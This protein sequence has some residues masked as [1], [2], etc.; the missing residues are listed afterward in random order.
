M[1]ILDQK[2]AVR[3]GKPHAN[4]KRPRTLLERVGETHF[5]QRSTIERHHAGDVFGRGRT[6]FHIENADWVLDLLQSGLKWTGLFKRGL[7]NV[8]DIQIVENNFYV[9]G[10]PHA[11]AGFTIMQLSDLHIDITP[12]LAEAIIDRLRL[13]DYDLCV[14]TGDYKWRTSGSADRALA[15]MRKIVPYLQ[16]PA[17]AV[18]G[19]H[20][21]LEFVTPV[22]EMGLPFLLNETVVL[23][24]SGER[25]YLSGV[26]DPHFYETD[27]LQKTGD[28]IPRGAVSILLAHSPEI[29]RQAAA[30]GYDIVLSGHTHAGQICL[31]GRIPIL[32]NANCPR[33]MVYGPWE[34]HKTQGYTSAG[35]GSSGVPVRFFCPP[36]ITLH[37]LFPADEGF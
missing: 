27:N 25:I 26:D 33:E 32:N 16:P 23:E 6:L 29:Y 21:F 17:Y 14:V 15:E 18:L 12:G 31:P 10:L 35:T 36:E 19:N 1:T 5:Q 37:R 34:F 7:Q 3:T 24:Q 9:P 22:E 11:F 13:L 4:G 20:D 8:L 28:K 2:I 30:A